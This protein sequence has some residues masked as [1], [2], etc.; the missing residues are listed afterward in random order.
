MH[1]RALFGG[2]ARLDGAGP[3]TT[4]RKVMLVVTDGENNAGA[5][6]FDVAHEIY[7]RSEGGVGM[8]FVAFDTDAYADGEAILSFFFGHETGVSELAG[9]SL[10]RTQ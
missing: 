1:L 3:L 5:R 7:S 9:V 6:P 10:E 4:F 2:S 8:Y